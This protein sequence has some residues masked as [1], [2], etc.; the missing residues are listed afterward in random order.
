[1]GMH[2]NT[3]ITVAFLGDRTLP[4]LDEAIR[5]DI[6]RGRQLLKQ[7]DHSLG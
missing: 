4:L 5:L 1:M 3:T 6:Y 7:P 2:M